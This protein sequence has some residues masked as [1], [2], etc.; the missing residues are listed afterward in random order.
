MEFDSDSGCRRK[1]LILNAMSWLGVRDDFRTWF[2][3]RRAGLGTSVEPANGAQL[4]LDD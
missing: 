4:P 3:P 1:P 2:V